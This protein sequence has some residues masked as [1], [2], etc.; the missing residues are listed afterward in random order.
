MS[1]M[2]FDAFAELARIRAD[3]RPVTTYDAITPATAKEMLTRNVSN[4]RIRKPAVRQMAAE[5][6]AG[7]W[8]TTHQGIAFAPDGRLLDGQ[9]RLLAVIAANVS[10][11]MPVT[12]GVHPDAFSVMDGAGGGAGLRNLRDATGIDPRILEPCSLMVRIIAGTG[13][14]TASTVTPIAA[15]PL[16]DAVQDLLIAAGKTVKRRTAAPIKLAAALR[17]SQDASG[18]VRDQ[19]AAFVHL[20]FNGMS[21]AMQSFCKQITDATHVT[22]TGGSA[23]LDSTARAWSA[24]DPARRNVTRIMLRDRNTALAEMQEIFASL[25]ARRTP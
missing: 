9:H 25:N 7:R 2:T 21:A 13:K 20:D 24:F 12:R 1:I 3:V 11:T 23:A 22:N 14:V 8:L 15:G 5:M 19:W 17:H 6:A 4:R 10:V 16:G 18:Y